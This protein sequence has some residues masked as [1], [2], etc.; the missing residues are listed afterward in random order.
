MFIERNA[1]NASLNTTQSLQRIDHSLNI[2][3][4]GFIAQTDEAGFTVKDLCRATG[5]CL[6]TVH[7]TLKKLIAQGLVQR[8]TGGKAMVFTSAPN[9]P[10]IPLLKTYTTVQS[11]QPLLKHLRNQTHRIVLYGPCATGADTPADAINL[12]IVAPDPQRVLAITDT[13]RIP[14]FGPGG[15]SKGSRR[16]QPASDPH[17]SSPGSRRLQPASDPH[18]SSP[19]S[20]KLQ[21]ASESQD[22]QAEARAY[23]EAGSA[24]GALPGIPSLEL[25]PSL[26]PLNSVLGPLTSDLS[27]SPIGPQSSVVGLPS[28]PPSDLPTSRLS[29]TSRK[30]AAII[31]PPADEIALLT[32]D[33]EADIRAIES[34]LLLWQDPAKPLPHLVTRGGGRNKIAIVTNYLKWKKSADPHWASEPYVISMAFDSHTFKGETIEPFF[35]AL[36]FPNV[37]AG[38]IL[39]MLGQ[40]HFFYGPRDPGAF[41]AISVFWMEKDAGV[42]DLGQTISDLQANKKIKASLKAIGTLAGE[43]LAKLLPGLGAVTTIVAEALKLNKDD[44]IFRSDGVYLREYDPPY[45]IGSDKVLGNVFLDFNIKVIGIGR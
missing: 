25:P 33:P 3:L 38:D 12:F 9:N 7:R 6:S 39:P 28:S 41:V 37:L 21:L 30:V 35:N 14:L 15:L 1:M 27:S 16:L 10:A 17:S 20:R 42:R 45:D 18:S 32:P 11:L 23:T 34:G 26:S 29:D 43:G 36:P 19:G 2:N 31:M 8:V 13:C 44:E 22:P 24:A 40:G 5:L 4:L